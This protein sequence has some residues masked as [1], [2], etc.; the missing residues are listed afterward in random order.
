MRRVSQTASRESMWKQFV[1][2]VAHWIGVSDLDAAIGESDKDE[3]GLE[4]CAISARSS[5]GKHLVAD[6]NL[7]LAVRA[8]PFQLYQWTGEH[9]SQHADHELDL[10]K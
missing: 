7:S 3:R 1:F 4:A 10:D 2:P 8:G 9:W 6:H 5:V